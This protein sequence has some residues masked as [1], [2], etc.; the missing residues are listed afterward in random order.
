M[1]YKAAVIGLGRMGST[2]DDE[3]T[4]GGSIFLPYC[5]APTYCAHPQIDLIAGADPHHEQRALFGERWG[6]DRDH[7]YANHLDLL[8]KA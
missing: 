6:V 1:S 2:F 4:Q 7:L 5:H 8:E 3:I